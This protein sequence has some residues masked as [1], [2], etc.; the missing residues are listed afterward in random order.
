MEKRLQ[1]LDACFSIFRH[2]TA[3]PAA[4]FTQRLS[5]EPGAGCNRI[6]GNR[7]DTCEEAKDDGESYGESYSVVFGKGCGNG[8]DG[9]TVTDS[10]VGIPIREHCVEEFNIGEGNG[11]ESDDCAGYDNCCG[12]GNCE[13]CDDG[14][15]L[16]RRP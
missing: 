14:K 8:M 4:S 3:E 12:D 1:R 6:S 11:E 7:V 15:G 5:I 16:R 10:D 9:S 2:S 13:E